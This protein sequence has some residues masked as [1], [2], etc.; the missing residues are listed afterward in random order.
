M[1]N[2]YKNNR[3]Q[4]FTIIEVMIVLAIAGLILL[5]V[6]LAVPALQRNA[7]NVTRKN[8]I[9]GI[10]GML[11][12]FESNNNGSLPTGFTTDS[13]GNTLTA[14]DSP[15]GVTGLGATVTSTAACS[16]NQESAKLGYY[17]ANNIFVDNVGST[18]E[19]PGTASAPGTTPSATAVT[20]DSVSIDFGETCGSSGSGGFSPVLS[21][22][23][24]AIWYVVESS[25]GNGSLQCSD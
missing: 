2:Q 21:D 3:S 1:L 11:S 24:Y 16:G 4:G 9:A 7:R 6:F 15:T 12:T 18:V 19:N 8:D 17:N 23:A 14:C 13:S 20:S 10:S 22:R 25:S 5:I